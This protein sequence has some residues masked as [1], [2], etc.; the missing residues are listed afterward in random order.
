VVRLKGNYSR[1]KSLFR[2]LDRAVWASEKALAAA[3][4]IAVMAA[5]GMQKGVSEG[6]IK[7]HFLGL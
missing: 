6:F 1:L 2:L 3:F 4:S 7:Y 5:K